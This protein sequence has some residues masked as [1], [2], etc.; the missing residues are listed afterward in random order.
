MKEQR[1]HQRIRFNVQPLVRVGQAGM[2]GLARLENLS[3][4][5]LLMRTDLPLKS[6]ET[7]GCEFSV[8]GLYLID[9]SAAVVGSVGELFSAR[10]QA[11]PISKVLLQ[12]EIARALSS[13]KGSVLSVNEL[14]GR[15]VMRV[16]GGLNDCLRTDFLHAL[17]TGVD[18][19]DL[20]K[21]TDIDPDG[22]ELCRTVLE[23][24]IGIIRPAVRVS[25]EIA[26]AAG[27]QNAG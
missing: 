21:V 22:A 25:D 27:W 24:R 20:S 3:L 11:G 15:R 16:Q 14:Q 2:S 12:D 5:G 17:K 26:A 19:V 4:G 6:G 10:F 8:F 13:G 7:F 9:I 18:E 1:R 23:Q